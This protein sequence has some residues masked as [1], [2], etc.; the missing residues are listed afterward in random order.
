MY[1]PIRDIDIKG[2][3]V[4]K[5]SKRLLAVILAVMI[6]LSAVTAAAVSVSAAAGDKVYCRA[7]FVPNCYMWKKNTE[8]NNHSWPGVAMT[9][10]SGEKDIYVYTVPDNNF[11]MIIFN[12]GGGQTGDMSYPGG[13]KLYDYAAGTWSDYSVDPVPVISVSKEGGSFKDSVDV[14]ITVTDAVTAYYTIDGG[15]PQPFSGSVTVTLGAYIAE[16]ASVRLDISA[17]NSYG[18]AVKS[19]TYK[20]RTS[21]SADGDGSTSPAIAGNYATNPNSGYGARKTITVD[22]SKSD[23]DSSMLIAQGVANDDPRVYAHWSMHEIAIDDYAMYAAWDNNNLYLMYEMCNVQDVVAPGEDFPM[24]QGN[25]WIYNLPVFLYI[26]T[27]NGNITHN[28]TAGG[29]LWDTG[30]TID[31]YSDFVIAFSTNASNGPFIYTANDDGQL[32]PDVLVKRGAETGINIKWGN[33]KTLSGKLMGLPKAGT[34]NRRK[35]GDAVDA[36]LTDFYTIRHNPKLDMF[37]EISIPL[38]NLGISASEIESNG[39]GVMKVSTFGTSGMDC[40][41][42]DLSMSDNAAKPYSK[43]SSTS[44]EKEDQDHITVPMARVGAAL[45]NNP[46]TPTAPTIQ[47]TTPPVQPT[48]P[49]AEPTEPSE[50]T[51]LSPPDDTGSSILGDTDGDGKVTV[52]DATFIQ[53]HLATIAIPF[54]ISTTVCDVDSDGKITV[55]DATYIQKWLA[56]LPAPEGIGQPI[57]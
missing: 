41:P 7:S 50:D 35:A 43:D 33:G 28:N 38:K 47:P 54:E 3:I 24:T 23:W 4:L 39:I 40:L 11:D 27:G 36:A 19:F 37:Y 18:T 46:V 44:A 49:Y 32:E 48:T 56:T 5:S 9:K 1:C 25:L 22:G 30:T 2:E 31:A 26:Y 29:T 21:V 57:G 13:N 53:K 55:V 34:D 20:K 14:T 16:G 45:S 51:P 6:T 52:L 42:Y 15:A 10:V 8:E 12:G 17:T